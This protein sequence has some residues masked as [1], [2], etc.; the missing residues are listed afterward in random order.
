MALH[1]F[2]AK[3]LQTIQSSQKVN[4]HRQK[5]TLEKHIRDVLQTVLSKDI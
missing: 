5:V 1:I 2:E 4:E 3:A